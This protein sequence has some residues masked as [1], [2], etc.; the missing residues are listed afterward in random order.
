MN[1]TPGVGSGGVDLDALVVGGGP[2]GSVT[3]LLLARAGWQVELVD[4]GTFP[5]GKACGECLNPAG[6][7]LLRELHLL[8]PVLATDPAPLEGWEISPLSEATARGR[9][10]GPDRALGIQRRTFDHALLQEARAAGVQVREGTTLVEAH[11]GD[12]WKP[13]QVQ[14]RL[15][16]GEH[17]ER[18]ARILVGA[19]GLRSRVAGA[20]GLALPPRGPTRAS[21]T[22]RVA[23]RGPSRSRGRLL[24]GQGCTVG[25]APVGNPMGILWNLT[26]VLTGLERTGGLR[27]DGWEQ[28]LE[29]L[30]EGGVRWSS[31]PRI[32]DGPW[33]SGSFHRPVRDVTRGRTLL[34]GDAAGYFDPLT[35]QGIFR[36]LRSAGVAARALTGQAVRV[37]SGPSPSTERLPPRLHPGD[38][39][40]LQNY[41]SALSQGLRWSRR[42]QKTIDATLARKTARRISLSALRAVPGAAS[43]LIR[44]TGDRPGTLL[45]VPSPVLPESGPTAEG[46]PA[47]LH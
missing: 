6:V 31:K 11:A 41:A 22:W 28:A 2:A 3:A 18:R 12:P 16:G 36:A 34:V 42:L 25:F 23:G 13:A 35:G 43:A 37:G 27:D 1:R 33:G 44:L 9:F 15:A 19:D 30:D 8:D 29:A 4:R 24:L 21:L 32:V 38:V 20:V 45:R 26:L 17:E 39:H 5:R 46:H 40:S 7:A 10:S 14:L 47:D